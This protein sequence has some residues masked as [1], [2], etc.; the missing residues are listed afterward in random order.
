MKKAI[1]TLT[2]GKEAEMFAKYSHP[3]MQQYAEKIGADFIVFNTEKVCYTGCQSI[4]SL[5]FEK[6][7]VYDVLE[8]YDRVAFLDSDILITPLAKDIFRAVPYKDIGGVFEDF[9]TDQ[10]DRRQIIQDIQKVLGNVNWR[11]GYLNSGVFVVSKCHRDIFK[12]IW[13]Y[14]VYDCKYEQNNTNWY[15]HKAGFPIKN[16][17]YKWN[18]M[19]IMWWYYGLDHRKAYFI[20]YAGTGIFPGTS[21]IDQIKADYEFFYGKC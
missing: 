9:G 18:Y 21:R 11:E 13:K 3:I 1:C 12:M 8:T 17:N 5:K 6:Y 4:N 14:G 19:N 16:M 20:H 15:M 2:L 10:D 7:Q